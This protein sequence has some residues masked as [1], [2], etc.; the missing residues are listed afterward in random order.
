MSAQRLL[1]QLRALPPH[2]PAH[3]FLV[4][5]PLPHNAA[6]PRTAGA[7]EL[8]ELFANMGTELSSDKLCEIMM[9]YDKDE[10]GQIDFA[11]FL[12]MFRDQLL[13]LQQVRG[14]TWVWS[15]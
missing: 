7:T 13:D 6:T 10:S 9:T 4:P 14:L 1:P 5:P 11:E 2:T 15:C 3:P 8:A 12:R